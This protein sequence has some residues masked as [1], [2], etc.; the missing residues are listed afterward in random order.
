MGK[1]FQEQGIAIISSKFQLLL[2]IVNI[3]ALALFLLF[4][5][6][7]V[8]FWFFMFL[9]FKGWYSF[10]Y[11]LYDFMDSYSKIKTCDC[12]YIDYQIVA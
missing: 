3:L 7:G 6:G 10:S 2:N 9:L 11:T 12:H 5:L 8:V 1:Y 4:F